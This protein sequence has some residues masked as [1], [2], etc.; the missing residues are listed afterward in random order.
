VNP[1]IAIETA[2]TDEDKLDPLSSHTKRRLTRRRF[3]GLSAAS[4]A[5]LALYAGEISRHELSIEQHTFQLP[6]LPDAFRGMRIVQVSDFHYAEYTEA[7]FLRDM[8]SRINQLT[9]DMVVLT[10]DFIS[11]SPMP[12]SFA[13]RH[14]APC[15]AI[16]SGIECPLRYAILGNHDYI[17]GPEYVAAPLREHGIPV[18]MNATVALERG[19]QRIWLGGLGSACVDK[20]D[21]AHALAGVPAGEP[22]IL[23][24]HEPDILPDIA[25]YNVDLMLSGH[26]HGGQVRIPF[27]PLFHLPEYGEKYIEGLFRLGP[28]QL[29][30]NRGIGAVGVPFRFRCPPEITVITLA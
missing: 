9:P 21:P 23:M 27:L 1:T 25:R 30:V 2:S 8:V 20:A 22:V 4:A 17:V 16:L 7:F 6:H 11:F 10:G 19:N 5:G 29:Y 13:Q 18:L 3:L 15:A 26:T 12:Q 24:A 14:A 28:T